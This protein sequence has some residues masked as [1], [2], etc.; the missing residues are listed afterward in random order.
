LSFHSI[1]SRSGVGNP[2]HCVFFSLTK[3]TVLS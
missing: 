1:K 2:L 3:V